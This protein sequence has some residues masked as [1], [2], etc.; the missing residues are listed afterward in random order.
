MHDNSMKNQASS[1]FTNFAAV[2]RNNNESNRS[3]SK[4]D[5]FTSFAIAP[6]HNNES[7]HPS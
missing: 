1:V 5:M 2:P 7:N 4:E 6:A 3:V